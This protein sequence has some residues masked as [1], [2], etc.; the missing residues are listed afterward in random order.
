MSKKVYKYTIVGEPI[1]LVKVTGTETP[2]VWDEYKQKR[3]NYEQTLRNQHDNQPFLEGPLSIDITFHMRIYPAH[4]HDELV[5]K[6][7]A[8][9]PSILSLFNFCERSL[10]GII[11]K[12]EC[13]IVKAKINKVYDD[14]P[15]TEIKI[16]R[17]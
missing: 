2:R 15:R 12:R 1:P 6:G 16:K 11:L 4:K 5:N 13:H 14:N 9:L 17:V 7:H 10:L 3:F 8:I